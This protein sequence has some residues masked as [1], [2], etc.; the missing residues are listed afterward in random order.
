MLDEVRPLALEPAPGQG[1]PCERELKRFMHG[2]LTRPE[3]REIVRHLLLGCPRC[4]QVTRRLW[5]LSGR[6]LREMETPQRNGRQ[7]FTLLKSIW[8]ERTM[9]EDEAQVQAELREIVAELGAL[10]A[11][12]ESVHDRLP[13][14]AQETA[15]LL[16]E[17]EMD[18]ATEVRSVIECVVHD[19]LQPA[20]RELQAAATYMPPAR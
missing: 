19:D 4:I 1:H 17:V 5:T 13:V 3:S 9:T 10:A 16:G 8:R 6:A 7:A 2:E 14:S 18:V 15:M 12:L 20:I 11:R